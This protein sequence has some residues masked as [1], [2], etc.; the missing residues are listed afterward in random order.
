M[1]GETF[2]QISGVTGGWL[3]AAYVGGLLFGI[4]W[5]AITDRAERSGFI[6]GYTALFVVG[7]VLITLALAALAAGLLPTLIIAG[8]FIFTGSP[9]IVGSMY[10]HRREEMALL[11][12]LRQEARHGDSGETMADER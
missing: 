9:M 10:R 3:A 12:K 4:G 7:G 2:G 11:R 1:I 8:E 6:R 5:N